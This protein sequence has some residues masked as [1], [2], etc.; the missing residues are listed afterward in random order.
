[1]CKRCKRALDLRIFFHWHCSYIDFETFG[2]SP[3]RLKKLDFRK[4]TPPGV[5]LSREL[6]LTTSVDEEA[7]GVMRHYKMERPDFRSG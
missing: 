4:D 7:A 2:S 3:Q 1:L 6:Q 5:P